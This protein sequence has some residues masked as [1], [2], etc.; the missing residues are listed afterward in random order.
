VDHAGLDAAAGH[1]DGEAEGVMVAA[2]GGL[3]AGGAAELGGPDNQRF[4]EKPA[5]LQVLEQAGDGL[6]DLHGEVGVVLLEILVGVPGV[7]GAAVIDLHEADAAFREPA[8]GE[9]DLAEGLGDL[10][11]EAIHPLRGFRFL[12]VLDGFG[13][14]HLHPEGELVGLDAGG[15]GGIVGILDGGHA[16]ELSQQGELALL[17]GLRE[18]LARRDEGERVIGID[19]ERDA[20]VLRA[21]V[22][23]AVGAVAA[24]T[25]AGRFAED[26][27]GGQVFV[28]RTEAVVDPGAE[29]GQVAVE[30]VAAGVELQDGAVVVVGG[31]GGADQRH[32]VHLVADVGEP[33][34]DEDAVFAAGLI[35]GLHGIERELDL[36]LTGDEGLEVFLDEGVRQGVAVRRFRKLLAGVFVELRLGVERFD[37][38]DAAEHE[39]PDDAFGFGREV[40]LGAG[41]DLLREQGA[42]GETGEAHAGV[43]EEDAAALG[44][45]ANVTG[46]GG[47]SSYRMVT[48]SLWLSR[49]CTRLSRRC[50]VPSR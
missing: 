50:W 47:L 31:P 25:V 11:V 12:L 42:E 45:G 46:H 32:F 35:A 13:D 26:D 27:V 8:S 48:K 14:G 38:G 22:A 41:D 20:G 49:T 39:E 28:H 6:V 30:D 4:I 40:G 2:V 23:G 34:G 33:V 10:L 29:G 18:F 17:V 24:A 3:G 21:E 5:L 36:V 44:I 7:A 16:V 43:G 15:E 1:E 19:V 9:A 37:V